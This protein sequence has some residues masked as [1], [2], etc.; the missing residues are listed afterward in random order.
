MKCLKFLILLSVAGSALA[1]GS[2]VCEP[3]RSNYNAFF[4]VFEDTLMD[5]ENF[6][7]SKYR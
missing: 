3:L 6:A 4:Q 5:A 1:G 2:S 7:I